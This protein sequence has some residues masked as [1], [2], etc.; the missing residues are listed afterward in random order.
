QGRNESIALSARNQ[1]SEIVGAVTCSTSY[2]WVLIK[3]RWVAES[4]RGAGLGRQLM[5]KAEDKA[6]SIGCHHAWLDTSNP[7][8]KRFYD[9]AG[10]AV[11]GTLEN[12]PDNEPAGHCRWFMKKSL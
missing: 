6:R 7:A 4:H 1:L 2:G 9:R 3:I 5:Q 12:G 8:A 10:Y 11:F